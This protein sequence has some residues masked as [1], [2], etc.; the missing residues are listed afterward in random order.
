M[1][2]Y[3]AKLADSISSIMQLWFNDG[4]F[5]PSFLFYKGYSIPVFKAVKEYI[6]YIERLPLADTPEIFGMHPNA[7]ITYDP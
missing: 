7:D 1:F 5:K 4:M 3:C 2:M 6:D